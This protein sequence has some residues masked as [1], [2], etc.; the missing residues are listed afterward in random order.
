MFIFK[1]LSAMCSFVHILQLYI[2]YINEFELYQ[3][4]EIIYLSHLHSETIH[5]MNAIS[6]V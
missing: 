3:N 1:Y 6:R 2:R 4:V 5:F